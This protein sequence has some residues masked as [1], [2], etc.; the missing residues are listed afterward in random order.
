[1]AIIPMIIFII[2]LPI[3]LPDNKIRNDWLLNK[4]FAPYP[5]RCRFGRIIYNS[6]IFGS[7]EF[8]R[9]DVLHDEG[10]LS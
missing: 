8:S 6:D 7:A 2:L 4:V 1:M 10:R 5:R 3:W 9:N